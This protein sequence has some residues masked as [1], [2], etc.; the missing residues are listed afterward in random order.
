MLAFRLFDREPGGP[1]RY[2]ALTAV[3]VLILAVVSHVVLSSDWLR[4]AGIEVGAHAAPM[5]ATTA[6]VGTSCWLPEE[7]V[8]Q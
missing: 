8:S 6:A 2:G 3:V 7:E 4:P 5:T 1:A